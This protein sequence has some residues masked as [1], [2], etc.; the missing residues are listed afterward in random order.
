MRFLILTFFA[1]SLAHAALPATKKVP[2]K[3][4]YK[5]SVLAEMTPVFQGKVRTEFKNLKFEALP[6]GAMQPAGVRLDNVFVGPKREVVVITNTLSLPQAK[7]NELYSLN[8][9]HF[10]RT[11]IQFKG[12]FVV[13]I[14]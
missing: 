8:G 5:I 14:L 3:A 2:P 9:N 7:A 4:R 11:G 13:A 10:Y 1:T 12:D 6:K